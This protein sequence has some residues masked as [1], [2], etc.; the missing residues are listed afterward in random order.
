MTPGA[1][2]RGS[3][4]VHGH[5]YQPSREDPFSGRTP[6]DASAAPSLDWTSRVADESYAPNARA[7]NFGRIGWDLGPT[8]ATW[9]RRERPALHDAIVAQ[10]DGRNGM[11]QAYHH[12][13]L[14][15]ASVRDR[16]T[17]IR[18]GLR[19]FELR[20]GRRPRGLWLPE[21]AVDGATLRICAEEGVRWTILAP[22]QAG[23]V[24][25]PGRPY[26]AGP[27]DAALTIGF[28][29][30]DLSAAVSFDPHA[31]TDADRFV[32][33]FVVPRLEVG[34]TIL[35]ATDGELYGHHRSFRELFLQRLLT[36][37]AAS[38]AVHVTSPGAWLDGGPEV[39]VLPSITI[40][41][42]TSW[43]CHHGVGRWSGECPC[44]PD[45][46]WKG[47]LRAA[48]DRLAAAVDVHT[49]L[50]LAPL[51][52]D[53]WEARDRYVD[54]ASG[55]AEPETWA[56]DELRR[57]SRHPGRV[58]GDAD[59]CETLLRMMCAQRSRL[60][61]FASDGWYWEDPRRP[62][63]AQI[64]RFAGHAAR[65]MDAALGTRLE[66]GLLEDLAAVQAPGAGPDGAQL[67]RAALMAVGQEVSAPGE[68]VTS[69]P[70]GS[71]RWGRPRRRTSVPR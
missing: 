65:L 42:R 64:L 60:S 29:D 46:R 62:E 22:T 56:M 21:A 38:R 11:A 33:R 53:A 44:A 45:G 12:T 48:L 54:V 55:Y 71:V 10:D 57:A 19:D 7:G 5:F 43:S 31:T 2:G 51:G 1:P 58:R 66:A 36:A 17:E 30:A 70:A 16:R 28:Y 26:R 37:A 47:P 69:G 40:R 39:S 35:I 8:L 20:V 49:E 15:L 61:M 9:L 24:V 27:P 23:G 41:D 4:A 18:W 59:A 32:D 50:G 63:T 68:P 3:L 14:P 25:D 34:E 6:P 13:I 67:Y 52:I